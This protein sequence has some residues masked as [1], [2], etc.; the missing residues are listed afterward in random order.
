MT[1]SA[2]E[3]IFAF[4]EVISLGNKEKLNIAQVKQLLVMDSQEERMAEAEQ[5]A[6]E[7]EAAENAERRR[8]ELERRRAEDARR[9]GGYSSSYGVGA[10]MGAMSS[11]SSSGMSRG[12]GIAAPQIERSTKPAVA[13]PSGPARKGL[14]LGGTAPKASDY[15]DTLKQELGGASANEMKE[16]IRASTGPS[17]SPSASPASSLPPASMRDDVHVAIS[18]K[19]LVKLDKDGNVQHFEV[20]GE[21]DVFVAKEQLSQVSIVLN[22]KA[23]A[24]GL[25]WKVHP[26]FHKPRFMEQAT[27]QMRD[28]AKQFAVN[29]PNGALKWRLLSQ[30]ASRLPLLVNCWPAQGGAVN[31]EYETRKGLELHDVTIRIPIVAKSQPN[32]TTCH[33]DSSFDTKDSILTWSIP[34]I[35]SSNASGNLDFDLEQWREHDIPNVFPINVK[36]T[37]E[38]SLCDIGVAKVLLGDQPVKFSS[39]TVVSVES[40]SIE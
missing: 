39:H 33:G 15:M 25:D 27:M 6:K 23:V 9:P 14:A 19:L 12:G 8:L 26:M 36:F 38:S 7:R 24:Q 28:N 13:A 37:S 10:P 29:A 20:R 16:M 17:P 4:D 32:I 22:P 1:Q 34:L 30:D 31:M 35:D 40:Y 3:L 21:L 5:R 2:F 11:M 18:E